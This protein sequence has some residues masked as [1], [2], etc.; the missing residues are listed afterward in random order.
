MHKVTA[1]LQKIYIFNEEVE[2]EDAS[3]DISMRMEIN[4]FQKQLF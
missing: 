2:G 1:T 3:D 4:Y